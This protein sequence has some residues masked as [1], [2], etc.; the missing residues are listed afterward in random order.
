MG[1]KDVVL[2]GLEIQLD[3]TYVFYGE[4]LT[5][6]SYIYVNGD[7]KAKPTFINDTRIES[8][9]ITLEEGDTVVINQL[10]S[11]SRIFRSS[12]EYVFRNGTLILKSEDIVPETNVENMEGN[13][14]NTP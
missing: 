14:S 8:Q 1:I 10:G 5:P 11:S 6:R 7:K 3:E 4:N 2:T 12:E 13:V 9:K